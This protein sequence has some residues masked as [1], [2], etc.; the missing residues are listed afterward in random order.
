MGSPLLLVLKSPEAAIQLAPQEMELMIRQARRTKLLGVLAYRLS[1]SGAFATLPDRVRDHL[2]AAQIAGG[3][4]QRMLDWE[5]VQ[6]HRVLNRAGIIP[7]LLKGAAYRALGLPIAAGRIASDVDILVAE[8]QLQK[9][10]AALKGAGWKEVKSAEYDQLYYRAWMHE[11]PPLRHRL[12]GTVVDVHRTIIPRTARLKPDPNKLIGA[13][14]AVGD[15]D[16]RVLCPED[17]VLHNV[18]HHFYTGEF[19]N[20]LRE[21]VDLDGLLRE[22]SGNSGFW[23]RLVPRAQELDLGRPLYYGLCFSKRLL[24][25]PIPSHVSRMAETGRPSAMVR[26]TMTGLVSS[27]LTPMV[28][29]GFDLRRAVAAWM[30]Y[31]R[32]HWLRMPPGLLMRHLTTKARMRARTGSNNT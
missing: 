23:D 32:S 7:I 31:I 19:D 9:T 28:P 27:A 6:L 26:A 10:E 11:L 1:D 24:D 30:L 8:A 2:S 14:V 12:R 4:F 29:G 15:G 16:L 17:M 25:T 3:V 21:L 22:F 13:S 5:T 18:A 20:S